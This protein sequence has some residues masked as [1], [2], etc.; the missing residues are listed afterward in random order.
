MTYNQNNMKLYKSI[1]LALIGAFAALSL[2]S[3]NAP[4]VNRTLGI[5]GQIVQSVVGPILGR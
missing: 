3:C 5:P 2:S 4:I 1:T